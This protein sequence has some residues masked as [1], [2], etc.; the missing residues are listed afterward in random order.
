M[1]HAKLDPVQGLQPTTVHALFI[2]HN[3]VWISGGHGRI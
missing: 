1:Q 3:S 2:S